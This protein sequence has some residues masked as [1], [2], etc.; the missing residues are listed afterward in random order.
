MEFFASK[1]GRG[2]KLRL[3]HVN[4]VILFIIILIDDIKHFKIIIFKLK[5]LIMS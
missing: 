5:Y 2:E 3:K 1:I 4:S